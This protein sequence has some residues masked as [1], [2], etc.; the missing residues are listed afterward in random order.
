VAGGAAR[1]GIDFGTSTTVAVIAFANREPRPLLFDGSPLLPSAVCLDPTGHIVVGRDALH[2]GT[3]DPASFEPHPK[4]CVDDGT[5]LLGSTELGVPALFGAVLRRVLDEARHVTEEPLDEVVITCPAAWGA[6][7]RTTLLAAA[8]EGARLVSEPVAAAHS[9][10]DV[11]GHRVPEGG[12]ALVYDFG[13]GTFDASVLRRTRDGFEVLASRGLPDSGGLDIDAAIV[14]HLRSAV[15]DPDGWHRLDEPATVNDRRS[16]RQLWDNVRAGKEMLSRTSTTLIHLPLLDVEVPLSRETIDE[17]AAPILARTVG[18]CREVAVSAGIET[19]ELSAIFLAGGSS[20]MPAVVTTLHRDLGIRPITV[21]QPELAVA[22]GSLRTAT[23]PVREGADW[24]APEPQVPPAGPN[25]SRRNR[26][27]AAAVAGGLLGVAA[28]VA[29]AY[30]GQ[31]PPKGAVGLHRA[32]PSA[33]ASPSY[34]PGID[35]CLLGVWR[36]TTYRNYGKIDGVDVQYSGGAG[37]VLTYNADG[38][39]FA[40][41]AAEQPMVAIY[42]GVRWEDT[43]RGWVKGTW[44]TQNGVMT[45]TVTE[46]TATSTLTRN[47]KYNNGGP[48]TF[49][50][51]PDQYFCSGDTLRWSSI[52]GNNAGEAVR[53]P[54]PSP[55]ASASS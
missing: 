23:Q 48:V 34:R 12:T 13:A 24:P 38:T 2:S 35:P 9:F 25:R 8:P 42:K 39:T 3:A 17:L 40:D 31:K 11:A 55:S 7:R 43:V 50:L 26:L 29:V 1:L 4:R 36:Q 21:D 47:G 16:R 18:A 22:E 41:Y 32:S 6:Q 52:Q 54:S 5:V 44:S 27:L 53:V 19:N 45:G 20:R 10:V 14:A 28:I 37:V 51:E 15:P 46:S 30:A 49:Y 33:S